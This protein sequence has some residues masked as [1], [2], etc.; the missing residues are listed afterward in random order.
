MS[1]SDR[2]LV[3]NA[4]APEQVK[5]GEQKERTRVERERE[6]LR[7]VLESR[8]GRRVLWRVIQ[9]CGVFASETYDPTLVHFDA[10]VRQAGKRLVGWINEANDEALSLMIREAMAAERRDAEDNAKARPAVTS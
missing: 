9:A 2:D 10:G 8:E 6:D 7:R 3:R 1:A 4:A 5:R